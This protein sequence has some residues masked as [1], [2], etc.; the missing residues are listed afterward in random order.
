[1][2]DDDGRL[3]RIETRLT[4]IEGEQRSHLRWTIGTI[5]ALS[6]GLAGLIFTTATFL[7]SRVDR[8]EERLTRLE[9]N[10]N[11]LPG[12]ISTS[13]NQMNQTLLQAVTAGKQAAPQVIVLP[14]PPAAEKSSQQTSTPETPK[15]E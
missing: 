6:L 8:V 14:A 12:K 5:L 11:D 3:G 13:L 7:T 1:M 10:I 4:N 9:S 15:R 2:S